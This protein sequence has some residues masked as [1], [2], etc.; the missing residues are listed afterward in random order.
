VP[1]K[2]AAHGW[3]FL[4]M[5][6]ILHRY[7]FLLRKVKNG[8]LNSGFGAFCLLRRHDNPDFDVLN[9]GAGVFC[10]LRRHD[11]PDFDVLNSGA[12][13]F[14]LLRRH[15]NP[16]FGVRN[17][18]FEVFY[19]EFGVPNSRFGVFNPDV[20]VVGRLS[21]IWK[22]TILLI[23]TRP[24]MPTSYLSVTGVAR[25][26]HNRVSVCYGLVQMPYLLRRHDN[27]H[28]R[29]GVNADWRWQGAG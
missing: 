24:V 12:G 9:S 13:F 19:A 7:F 23:T 28:D 21:G 20:G 6:I 26:L 8:V 10:L 22:V 14:C 15:N 3:H 2:S 25:H 18:D 1:C 11:N 17:P 16:D 29:S 27:R 4:C 5:Q